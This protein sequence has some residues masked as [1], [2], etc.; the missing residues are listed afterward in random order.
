MRDEINTPNSNGCTPLILCC[1]K[2]SGGGINQIVEYLLE[3][4]AS[5]TYSHKSK[6]ALHYAITSSANAD[7]I[8]LI[9]A[10]KKIA[11]RADELLSIPTD[12]NDTALTFAMN[13]SNPQY[14]IAKILIKLNAPCRLQGSS[15]FVQILF[16]NDSFLFTVNDIVAKLKYIPDKDGKSYPIHE[17]IIAN[18]IIAPFVLLQAQS[19]TALRSFTTKYFTFDLVEMKSMLGSLI[20]ASASQNV[21]QPQISSRAM[22]G[23][24]S[25]RDVKYQAIKLLRIYCKEDHTLE[26]IQFRHQANIYTLI[27]FYLFTI[28]ACQYSPP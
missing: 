20:P 6:N 5:I 19:I 16:S 14:P 8:E 27:G 1:K 23:S 2:A 11:P 12:T 4:G 24:V 9:L 28:C 3:E 10:H 25:Q 15:F 13:P 26:K 21:N 7:L 18:H 22:A 17:G